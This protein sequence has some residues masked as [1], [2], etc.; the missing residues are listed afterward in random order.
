MRVGAQAPKKGSGTICAMHP[1]GRCRQM[2]PDP[3][4]DQNAWR[5]A[6]SSFWILNSLLSLV[7]SK[8]S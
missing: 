3:F 5:A 4:S 2:V 1:K 8:T 7:I 6:C